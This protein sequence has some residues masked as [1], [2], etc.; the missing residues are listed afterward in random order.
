MPEIGKGTQGKT[1]RAMTA[2]ARSQSLPLPSWMTLT[3]S[4]GNTQAATRLLKNSQ[5]RAS[6]QAGMSG[7][8]SEG[9]QEQMKTEKE[10]VKQ[11]REVVR[12][13][14]QLKRA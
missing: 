6:V 3:V 1:S 10:S 9:P 5:E 11:N 12:G 7:R 4:W 14:S 2:Y 8:G 13:F